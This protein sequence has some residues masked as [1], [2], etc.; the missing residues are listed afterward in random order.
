MSKRLDLEW[1][2]NKRTRDE[3]GGCRSFR[4]KFCRKLIETY[5]VRIKNSGFW[6]IKSK[7][8]KYGTASLFFPMSARTISEGSRAGGTI[9]ETLGADDVRG[10]RPKWHA[11][12]G[13]VSEGER[14]R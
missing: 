10:V 7:F 6:Q 1:N 3:A 4:V 14:R 8:A 13:S 5:N 12:E 2:W 11:T 9:V